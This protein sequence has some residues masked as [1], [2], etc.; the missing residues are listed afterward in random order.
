MNPLRQWLR[1]GGTTPGADSPP[2]PTADSDDPTA[3]ITPVIEI[4]RSPHDRLRDLS[5]GNALI[6]NLD[7][8]ETVLR[9]GE[10]QTRESMLAQLALVRDDLGQLCENCAFHP[11]SFE[12]G[13]LVDPS[14]RARIQI[15]GG[16]SGEGPTRI[17]RTIRCGYLYE[18][19]GDEAS[20]VI[21]KAE[22]EIG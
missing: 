8:L 4:A 21:R 14:I 16:S 1:K 22:V 19:G 6:T 2:P 3:P 5:I 18:P 17:A 12:P 20:A 11:F 13:T 7:R 9:S 15:V 10:H